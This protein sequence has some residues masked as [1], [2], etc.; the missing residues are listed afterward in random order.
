MAGVVL[1]LVGLLMPIGQG[2]GMAPP[3]IAVVDLPAVSEQYQKT[4]DLEAHFEAVRKRLSEERDTLRDKVEL[5]ERSLK[6]ELKPG[7]EE[8]NAR[9]KKLAILEAELKYFMESEAQ[10]VEADLARSLRD[11][12]ADIR[13]IIRIVAAEKNVDI[14]LSADRMPDEPPESPTQVRQ[15]ILLQKVLHWSSDVDLT[16]QVVER[17]NAKYRATGGSNAPPG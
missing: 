15:Q 3:R 2:D 8:Y 1:V 13:E 9:R 11:I 16:A 14:V 17:L 10:K 5:T 4:R 7:T 12:F 6:E